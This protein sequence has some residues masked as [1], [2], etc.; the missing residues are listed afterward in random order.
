[1]YVSAL[2]SSTQVLILSLL[3]LKGQPSLKL[4][5]KL[6]IVSMLTKMFHLQLIKGCNLHISCKSPF[7]LILPLKFLFLDFLL[8]VSQPWFNLLLK[9][10]YSA[11]YLSSLCSQFIIFLC[12][13]KTLKSV[14]IWEGHVLER[15]LILERSEAVS[16]VGDC[17]YIQLNVY[18]HLTIIWRCGSS[19]ELLE[20]GRGWERERKNLTC[21]G[22]HVSLWTGHGHAWG[23][24]RARSAPPP[25]PLLAHSAHCCVYWS[26]TAAQSCT[27]DTHKHTQ[28]QRVEINM[29]YML[30]VKLFFPNSY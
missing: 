6:N 18:G 4:V 23:H 8:C 14:P 21:W 30:K 13:S 15:S 7:I 5:C 28:A 22:R 2:L 11:V 19:P 25:L 26:Y 20:R 1:M 17:Y 3:F 12:S 24:R 29:L 16:A 10:L 27:K 9:S